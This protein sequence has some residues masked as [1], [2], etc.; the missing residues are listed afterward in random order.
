MCNRDGHLLHSCKRNNFSR[1]VVNEWC[2]RILN[3]VRC[4]LIGLN[5]VLSMLCN[6][7]LIMAFG[8]T[9]TVILTVIIYQ[10]EGLTKVTDTV[11]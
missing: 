3:V 2:Q 4:N 7:Q 9:L 8:S 1:L 5:Y 10:A 6:N 11:T